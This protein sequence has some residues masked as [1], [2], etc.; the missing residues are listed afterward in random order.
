M[1]P[2]HGVGTEG[3]GAAAAGVANAKAAAA[4]ANRTPSP[5]F[6]M[7]AITFDGC[8]GPPDAVRSVISGLGFLPGELPQ[9]IEQIS[10]GPGPHGTSAGL[11]PVVD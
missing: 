11:H 1:P 5:R 4:T 10:L 6:T 9:T 2:L 3:V 8:T 7:I